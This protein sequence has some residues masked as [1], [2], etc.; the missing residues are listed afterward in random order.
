MKRKGFTLIEL[1]VVIAI[2]AILAAI[3]FPVFASAREKARQITCVSNLDQIGMAAMM[4]TQDNNEDWFSIYDPRNTSDSPH[5]Y[6]R[7]SPYIKSGTGN[8]WASYTANNDI[9]VCPDGISRQFNYSMNSHIS[10]VD[11]STDSFIPT[12]NGSFTHPAQ[13]IFVAD[14]TQVGDYGWESGSG[15][16]WWPGL[17][18]NGSFPAN[19]TQWDTLDND[20]QHTSAASYQEVRYRHTGSADFVFID[21]HVQSMQRGSVQVPWNWCVTGDSQAQA[22]QTWPQ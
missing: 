14:A 18:P 4:Y 5:W 16:D 20:P 11:W 7:V 12:S 3:L 22:Q 13:T 10:P 15:F 21:G 17:M 1:L 9:R 6:F 19:A 8:S 2:I